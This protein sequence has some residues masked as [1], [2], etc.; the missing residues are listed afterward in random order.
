MD[1]PGTFARA[2]ACLGAIALARSPPL[3]RAHDNTP[4]A[5][6]V[7]TQDPQSVEIGKF[8]VAQRRILLQNVIKVAFAPGAIADHLTS[9]GATGSYGTVMEPC[10]LPE[11][12][13]HPAIA[14]GNYLAGSA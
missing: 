1:L 9:A 2:A 14:I 3:A 13:P 11:K 12:F 6:I 5:V 8:C 7:N 4:R 10:N